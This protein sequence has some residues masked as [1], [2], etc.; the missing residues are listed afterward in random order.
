MRE[1]ECVCVCV[2]VCV[3]ERRGRA[4][5]QQDARLVLPLEI[6]VRTTSYFN[7]TLENRQILE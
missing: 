2:H 3:R 6:C 4:M 7:T 1:R 5:H